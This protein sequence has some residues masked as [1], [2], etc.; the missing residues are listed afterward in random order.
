MYRAHYDFSAE[1]QQLLLGGQG[2]LLSAGQDCYCEQPLVQESYEF[3]R[4]LHEQFPAWDSTHLG[5]ETSALFQYMNLWELKDLWLFWAEESV[6]FGHWL[7]DLTKVLYLS[8]VLYSWQ[9]FI[10][11][12]FEAN[13]IKIGSPYAF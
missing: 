1:A 9:D 12:P 13:E 6:S 7:P 5:P 10:G 4:L 3:V 11:N 2:H 8:F